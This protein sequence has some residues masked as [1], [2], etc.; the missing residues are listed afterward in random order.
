MGVAS[1]E[2]VSSR[3]YRVLR[4]AVWHGGR[5]YVLRRVRRVRRGM[6]IVSGTGMALRSATVIARRLTR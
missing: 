1:I 4:F 5:W 6:L 2:G 3:T